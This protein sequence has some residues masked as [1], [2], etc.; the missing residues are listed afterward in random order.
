MAKKIEIGELTFKKKGDA[1]EY[2]RNMLAKYD[3]GD[4][5]SAQ[6]SKILQDL[7]VKHP[8]ANEKVGQGIDFFSVR[9]ADFGT[10]CFWVT[11]MDDTSVKFSFYSCL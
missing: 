7:L 11:R 6:D 4:R 3:V 9:S 10:K 2:F 8:D 1:V 5:V